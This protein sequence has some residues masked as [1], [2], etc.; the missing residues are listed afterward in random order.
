MSSTQVVVDGQQKRKKFGGDR[1]E[2]SVVHGS[3]ECHQLPDNNLSTKQNNHRVTS[4]PLPAKKV[5]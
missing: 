5:V 1:Q 4:G 3:D 2:Y